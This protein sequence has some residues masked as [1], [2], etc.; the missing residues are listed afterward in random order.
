MVVDDGAAAAECNAMMLLSFAVLR[1]G[2]VAGGADSHMDEK[3]HIYEIR[4]HI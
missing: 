3:P 1:G 4:K 2:V